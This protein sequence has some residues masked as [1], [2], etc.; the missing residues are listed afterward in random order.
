LCASD[1]W[2]ERHTQAAL[3][4][5]VLLLALRIGWLA[6]AGWL[7]L[8]CVRHRHHHRHRPGCHAAVAF[9]GSALVIV[10]ERR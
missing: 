7:L 2:R 10:V 5:S 8:F 1:A 3:V 9:N 6:S 4:P